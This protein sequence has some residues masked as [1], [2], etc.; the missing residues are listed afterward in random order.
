MSEQTADPIGFTLGDRLRKARV[1]AGLDQTELAQRIAVSR[2]TVSNYELGHGKRP[3][4]TLV[5]RAWAHECGVSYDDLIHVDNS[6]E[7]GRDTHE[8]RPLAA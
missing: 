1:R 6:S 7:A 4:K 3:P 2:G 5:L 8:D